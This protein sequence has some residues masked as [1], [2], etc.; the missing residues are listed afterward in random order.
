MMREVAG[1]IFSCFMGVTLL[2]FMLP[3]LTVEYEYVKLQVDITDPMI[4]PM[5][6]LGDGIYQIMP[7]VIVLVVGFSVLAYATRREPFDV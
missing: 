1:A 5:V 2:W 4:A 7:F 3:M 6:Q